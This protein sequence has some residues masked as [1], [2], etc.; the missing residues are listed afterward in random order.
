MKSPEYDKVIDT[1]FDWLNDYDT[2]DGSICKTWE[3]RGI[4]EDAPDEAKKAYAYYLEVEKDMREHG[5]KA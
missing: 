2:G 4:R 1:F 3:E 5:V